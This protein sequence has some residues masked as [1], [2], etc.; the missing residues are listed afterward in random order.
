MRWADMNNRQ[1][2]DSPMGAALVLVILFGALTF[3]GVCLAAILF[4]PWPVKLICAVL[5]TV[6]GLVLAAALYDD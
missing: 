1:K 6:L 3:F 5:M 2:H 4:A